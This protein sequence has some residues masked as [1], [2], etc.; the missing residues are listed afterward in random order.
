MLNDLFNS[1]SVCIVGVS[2]NDNSKWGNQILFNL[3]E[4]GY[5]GNVY[6]VNK[7]GGYINDLVVYKSVLDTPSDSVG[8]MVVIAVPAQFVGSILN[9]MVEKNIKT[10]LIISAGFSEIGNKKMEE[11]IINIAKKGNIKIIAGPNSFGIINKKS[12]L[13]LSLISTGKL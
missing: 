5:K 11:E 3:L 8:K 10:V 12:K 13:N 2:L 7:K 6:P 1:S 4:G 9:E